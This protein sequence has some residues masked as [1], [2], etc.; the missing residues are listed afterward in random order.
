MDKMTTRPQG[1][2][3]SQLFRTPSRVERGLGLWVDRVGERVDQ[4]MPERMRLLGL[5]GVVYVREGSGV[6]ESAVTGT[7]RV[8][9]GQC[10]VL[11]PDVAHRYGNPDAAWNTCWVVFGGARAEALQ[12]IGYLQPRQAV[13]SDNRGAV[14]RTYGRLRAIMQHGDPAA[15]LERHNL[16]HQMV[17]DLHEQRSADTGPLTRA[18]LVERVVTYLDQHFRENIRPE[19]V[20]E[21]FAISYTHLR[22]LFHA[23]MG[24][25]MKEHIVHRRLSLAKS[26]LVG[27]HMP[28]KQVARQVGYDDEYYFMRLFKRHVGVS[29]GRFE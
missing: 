20:A 19:Q 4:S 9:A 8:G 2:T 16:V 26:L 3:V 25:S 18:Q 6:F 14:V 22:R 5:Y 7:V 27:H 17:L 29:P 12:R 24:Q 13:T 11:F 23:A 15:C 1:V 28:I 21:R 10:L